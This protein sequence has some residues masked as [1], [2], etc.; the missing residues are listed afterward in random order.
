[1]KGKRFLELG[2]GSGL[3]AFS[4]AKKGAIVTATD[5]NQTAIEYLQK[6][7][8]ANQSDIEIIYS[9]LFEKIPQ[10]QFDIIA[11]N[12]PYYKKNPSTEREYAWYCGEHGEYF[13]KLFSTIN[14]YIHRDTEIYM[15]ISDDSDLN[16]I[17]NIAA[18]N[19]FKFI[20]VRTKR[21]FWEKNYIFKIS[22]NK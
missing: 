6:N 5:I 15:V 18:K 8:A 9:D 10:Q 21:I 1:M 3:I 14:S 11:I 4:A 12:P 17:N 19:N 16:M 13:D 2:A 22:S 7:K 20:P